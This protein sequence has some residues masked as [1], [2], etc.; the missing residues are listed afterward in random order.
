MSTPRSSQADGPQPFPGPPSLL[1]LLCPSEIY[2]RAGHGVQWCVTRTG[3]R[4]SSVQGLGS[5]PDIPALCDPES[6]WKADPFGDSPETP[7]VFSQPS[8]SPLGPPCKDPAPLPGGWSSWLNLQRTLARLPGVR[9]SALAWSCG[10]DPRAG[11]EGRSCPP[12]FSS[13]AHHGGRVAGI[14]RGVTLRAGAGAGVGA[15]VEVAAQGGGQTLQVGHCLLSLAP[16]G[17]CGALCRGPC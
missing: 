14:I 2:P 10:R 1:P 4:T 13:P 12:S 11:T 3:L 7:S 5:T 6:F 15:F 9:G 17:G 16:G 8:P